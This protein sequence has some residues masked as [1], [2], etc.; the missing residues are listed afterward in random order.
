MSNNSIKA[1]QLGIVIFWAVLMH[2]APAAIGFG[3]FLRHEG[4]ARNKAALYMLVS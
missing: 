4:V 2:K 3:T 1:S